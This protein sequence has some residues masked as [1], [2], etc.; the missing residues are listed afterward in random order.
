MSNLSPTKVPASFRDPNGFVFKKG[1]EYF[2]QINLSYKENYDFLIKSGLFKELVDKKYLINHE[3]IS[4]T[5]PDDD[6]Y[7]IIR[8]EQLSF[9]SYP[10]EWCFSQLKDAATL[11]LE[12]QE[13]AMKYGM[14]L[15]DASAYNIQFF[16]G[17]P[18]LIDTLSFEK[19]QENKPWIAYRQF[20][21]HFLAPLAL[22]SYTD[23]RLGALSEIHLDGVPLDLAAKLLPG[24]TRFSFGLGAHIFLHAKSQQTNADAPAKS[25]SFNLSKNRLN[26]IIDS[27]KSTVAALK[28]VKQRTTW[29]DY[30]DNT[31]YSKAGFK[32]KEKTITD[33]INKVKP[34]TLWDAGA[35]DGYFSRL[36]SKQKIATIATD[37]DH[38]A[39]EHAYLR[40]K[41]EK[42]S[43]L[44]PLV[45]DLTNPSPSIGW[46]NKERPSFLKRSS[47]DLTLCLALVH[48]LAIANN[49]PLSY[50]AELFHDHTKHMIIEFVSKD[51]SNTARLLAN[52]EDIF[53]NYTQESFE[54]EFSHF[55]NIIAKNPVKDS[56]R[57]L[58]LMEKKTD[59]I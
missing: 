12:I 59:V 47:F 35:N 42:D 9:L 14:S 46:Q 20:C 21:Q 36:G 43:S 2:R 19:Y 52:R 27:L 3:E 24:K 30:Y 25:G 23:V 15:K 58:Y 53:V 32:D 48:H 13:I 5:S 56:K 50:I 31:N 6:A 51:D 1:N 55:F 37:F 26:G 57:T 33:W 11:T 45:I 22:L 54:K 44:Q 8:P 39:I 10:Y 49:L 38:I 40:S 29:D 4:L 28:L 34:K 7:K 41:D 17:K 16:Q 18:I